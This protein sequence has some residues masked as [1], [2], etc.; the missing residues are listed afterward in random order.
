MVVIAFQYVKYCS[1]GNLERLRNGQCRSY[2]A[3]VQTQLAVTSDNYSLSLH[4]AQ[5]PLLSSDSH[6]ELL[7]TL[8]G[9]LSLLLLLEV[10][11]QLLYPCFGASP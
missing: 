5:L 9:L 10:G 4:I 8:L 1:T 3:Q 6:L 11:H 7:Y 2:W